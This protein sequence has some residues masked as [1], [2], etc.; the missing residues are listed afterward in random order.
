MPLVV[1]L[2]QQHLLRVP[3]QHKWLQCREEGL[4]KRLRVVPAGRLSSTSPHHQ[5]GT[6]WQ[7]QKMRYSRTLRTMTSRP[8]PSPDLW[9]LP[10]SKQ[11]PLTSTVSGRRRLPLLRSSRKIGLVLASRTIKL[12]SSIE[13][14]SNSADSKDRKCLIIST[15]RN[16]TMT[17]MVP[18]QNQEVLP[19][20]RQART[21]LQAMRKA[22]RTSSASM[23]QE[24]I[25]KRVP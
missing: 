15:A 25:R 17:A 5:A 22:S 24:K 8:P 12:G 16:Q 3:D 1:T 10:N 19:R 21:Q 9:P 6:Q 11:Q 18:V 23:W 7:Q 20:K 4:A 14:V 13:L 2:R